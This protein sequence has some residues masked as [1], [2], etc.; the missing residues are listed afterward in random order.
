[1]ANLDR[2]PQYL[3]ERA[4]DLL[5]ELGHQEE[6]ADS[7]FAFTPNGDYLRHLS[8]NWSGPGGWRVLAEEQ[9]PAIRFHYRQSP[10]L[11]A[12]F[13]AP[14]IG[15]WM[16][17]PPMTVPGMAQVAL[18]AEG[19]LDSLWIV[20]PERGSEI[21]GTPDW[22]ILLEAA[23]FDPASLTA[24][25]PEWAP[26]QY[27]DQRAAWTGFSPEA[28][29]IPVRL[30]A[31]SLAGKVVAFR[32]IWPWTRPAEVR[33]TRS[34]WEVVGQTISSLWFVFVLVAAAVVA[35]RNLR[36]GR[37]DTRGA[38]RLALY[39]GTI[40]MLWLIGAHFI[41]SSELVGLLIGHLAYSLYRVGVVYVFYLAVEPYARRFW[42]QVLVSW[43]RLLDGRFLDPLVGR[44][45]LIGTVGGVAAGLSMWLGGWVPELLGLSPQQPVW[46]NM[47]GEALRGLRGSLVAVIAVHTEELLTI[48]FPVTLLVLLRLLFRKTW[49]AVAVVSLLVTAMFYPGGSGV[50]HLVGILV[51]L[52]IVWALFFRAGL[53]AM[54]V[55]LTI[56]GLI[57]SLPFTLEPSAWYAGST[58]LVVVVI[59]APALLGLRSILVARP[60]I[61]LRTREA[62]ATP[63]SGS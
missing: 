37:G 24:A 19:R 62:P 13:S 25:A 20:P 17:D 6:P 12:R 3:Q 29:E 40:R 39:L 48:I 32:T 55:C 23:G 21:E 7:L 43:V 1:M 60:A 36:A 61:P 63:S 33:S 16:N 34:T 56:S 41:P 47:T 50:G 2:P 31:A 15:A 45:L 11:L 18:D 42:P 57:N 44:S 26:P 30:E 51:W 35:V 49:L 10:K 53:L 38:L 8:E 59:L 28:P 46:S 27:A 58:F 4:R 9:P 22:S 52:G 14:S 54:A 5:K